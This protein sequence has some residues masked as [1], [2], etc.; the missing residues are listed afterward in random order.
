MNK[1]LKKLKGY[2]N[3][4]DSLRLSY[5]KRRFNNKQIIIVKDINDIFEDIAIYVNFKVIFLS[6]LTFI[7]DEEMNFIN[8]L[9]E[10]SDSIL[11]FSYNL[12]D[13]KDIKKYTSVPT[14][15]YPTYLS[16]SPDIKIKKEIDEIINKGDANF[17]YNIKFIGV[18]FYNTIVKY[19]L[20]SMISPFMT[21]RLELCNFSKNYYVKKAINAIKKIKHKFTIVPITIKQLDSQTDKKSH[22]ILAIYIK[23]EDKFYIFDS[24]ISTSDFYSYYYN[25]IDIFFNNYEFIDH[26]NKIQFSEGFATNLDCEI[27]GYCTIWCCLFITFYVKFNNELSMNEIVNSILVYA[28]TPPKLRDL[29]RSFTSLNLENHIKETSYIIKDEDFPELTL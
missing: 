23:K 13:N 15:Y 10:N 27:Y 4:I 29:I 9:I 20:Y 28:N 25:A 21:T 18:T 11:L 2:G 19:K 26:A 22:M 24:N 6:D 7:N 12:V 1:I 8:S 16:N 3:N 17:V 5:E 14:F